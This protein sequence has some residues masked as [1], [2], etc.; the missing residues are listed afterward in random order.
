MTPEEKL[1]LTKD[2]VK[3]FESFEKAYKKC[4]K[5]GIRFYSV[6]DRITAFNGKYIDS[7][8]DNS[9]KNDFCLNTNAQSF[10]M[11][12]IVDTNFANWSDDNHFVSFK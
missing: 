11:F 3:A 6:I 2:Q 8:H 4:K 7:I 5:T 12:N 1:T 9:Y 10:N